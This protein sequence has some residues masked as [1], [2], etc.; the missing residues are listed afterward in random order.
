MDGRKTRSRKR[1]EGF[2]IIQRKDDNALYK[3]SVGVKKNE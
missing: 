1:L 3:V 2:W